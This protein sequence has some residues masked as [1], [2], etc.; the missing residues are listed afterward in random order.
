MQ[1]P[2][3]IIIGL[4]GRAGAGKDTAAAYLCET[5]GFVQTSFAD[6][7]RSMVQ[8]F[9]EEAGIDHAFVHERDLKEVPVP[10][11]GV[12]ARQMMQVLGTEVGRHVSHDLWLRHLE[13]RLGLTVGAQPV[14]DRIVVSD[15]R[16]P[17]EETWVH[18]RGGRVIRLHRDQAGSVR[19]HA[20]ERYVV[21]LEADVDLHNHGAMHGLHGLLDGTMAAWGIDPR[22]EALDSWGWGFSRGA[23]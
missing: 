12:S 13:L 14:H 3:P 7:I 11:L 18:A 23:A 10:A 21:E 8:L 22:P 19:H 5:Y 15:V 17:N 16:F 20:S 2:D 9:L 4:T 1:L 6:P